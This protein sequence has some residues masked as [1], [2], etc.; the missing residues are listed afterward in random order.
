MKVNVEV[1][2]SI[3]EEIDCIESDS[4]YK[5]AP[6]TV[7]INAPLAL[8]QVD[9]ESRVAALKWALALVGKFEE[10]KS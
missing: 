9:L 6:A 7:Q 1:V 10:A 4:R 2:N 8:I 3:K 5:A